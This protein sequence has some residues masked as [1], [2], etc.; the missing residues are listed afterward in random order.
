MPAGGTQFEA[1]D[2]EARRPLAQAVDDEQGPGRRRQRAESI[3]ELGL[4]IIQPLTVSGTR[5]ALV[6]LQ[7]QVHVGHVVLREQGRELQVHFAAACDG[8]LER[9]FPTLA[10]C[11]HGPL[12]QLEVEAEPDLL[13]LAALFLAEEFAGTAYL[14]VLGR[15]REARAKVLQRFDRLEP[16]ACIVRQGR[17]GRCEQVGEGA[18]V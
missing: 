9:R 3:D 17:H 15:E 7:A 18:V 4:E 16:L 14:E 6:E 5:H 13:D 12:E 2:A 10:Q 11:S 1:A 8:R